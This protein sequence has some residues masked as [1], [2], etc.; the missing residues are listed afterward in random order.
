MLEYFVILISFFGI[1]FGFLLRR[2]AKEE[3]KFGKFGARYFIWLKRIIL[4]LVI[5]ILLYFSENYLIVIIFAIIGF[6]VGIYLDEYLFLGFGLVVGFMNKNLLLLISSLI[7]IN[8]LV[9]GSLLRNLKKALPSLL[10]FVPFLL[11]IFN[12][13]YYGYLI[14]FSCGGLLNYIIRK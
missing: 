9:Y 1:F 2:I 12:F 5:L 8:G 11:L 7:F 4:L 6:I 13:D 14:G 3:I 10:F